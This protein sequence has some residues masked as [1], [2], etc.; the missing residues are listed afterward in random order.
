MR[1]SHWR[2]THAIRLGRRSTCERLGNAIRRRLATAFAAAPPHYLRWLMTQFII[3]VLSKLPS[4]SEACRDG[5]SWLA[6]RFSRYSRP[7]MQY[8]GT[9][10]HAYLEPRKCHYSFMITHS[11]VFTYFT[12]LLNG[13]LPKTKCYLSHNF[14]NAFLYY[15][16]TP[17]IIG[18][19]HACLFWRAEAHYI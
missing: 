8:F 2:Q 9:A 12:W 6:M 1:H 4:R 17:I 10:H 13:T 7:R 19:C 15:I 18:E 16:I 5:E 3:S 11:R 14:I